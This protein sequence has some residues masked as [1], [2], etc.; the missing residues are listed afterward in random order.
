MGVVWAEFVTTSKLINSEGTGDGSAEG[1]WGE[2]CV[3][4]NN[5]MYL[6]AFGQWVAVDRLN[7]QSGHTEHMLRRV[8]NVEPKSVG[9]ST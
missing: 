8:A 1:A 4:Y 7:S 2:H 6:S 3:M 5:I 9:F